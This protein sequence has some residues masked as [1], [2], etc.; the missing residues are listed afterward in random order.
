MIAC[1]VW[2][3]SH[4]RGASTAAAGAGNPFGTMTQCIIGAPDLGV[5]R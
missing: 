5:R 2:F 1:V 3:C 4:P